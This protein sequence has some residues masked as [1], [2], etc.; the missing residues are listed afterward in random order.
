MNRIH[1]GK[2]CGFVEFYVTNGQR[3]EQNRNHRLGKAVDCYMSEGIK[4]IFRS[5]VKEIKFLSNS[6]RASKESLCTTIAV[7]KVY[8]KPNNQQP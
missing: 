6:L 4:K 5:N 2:P 1:H 7:M 3:Q 8:L